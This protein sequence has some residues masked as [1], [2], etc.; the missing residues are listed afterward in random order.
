MLK[1]S[2]GA[3]GV[4]ATKR[5]PIRQLRPT[6]THEAIV[7]LLEMGLFKYIISQ[8]TDGL[9]RLSG[10]PADKISELHGN[11][12][13]QKCEQCETRYDVTKSH[14]DSP[15]AK[16]FPIKKCERRKINHRTGRMCEKKVRQNGT[17]L[18][19][20]KTTLS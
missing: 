18:D 9:H 4:K 17:K 1:H 5:I 2:L 11:A 15:P 19:L 6:Y 16:N 8:N 3:K 14:R 20:S 10:V 7:K 12:F 13:V